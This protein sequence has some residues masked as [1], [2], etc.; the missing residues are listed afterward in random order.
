MDEQS[1]GVRVDR[2]LWCARFVKSRS[3]AIDAVKAGRVEVNGA[4]VKPSREVR[5]GDRLEITVG[6][7]CRTVVIQATAERRGPATV[8]AR[9]YTETPES[10]AERE[11]QAAQR[12]LAPAPDADRGGRPTKR[13]R[14]RVDAARRRG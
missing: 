2:W 3:L 13:D 9:L 8:A 11:R 7:E 6:Q 1:D 4:R 10:I 12:R 5:P 14:R